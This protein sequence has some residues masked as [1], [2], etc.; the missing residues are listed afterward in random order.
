MRERQPI[1]DT[2]LAHYRL[3]SAQEH[4]RAREAADPMIRRIHSTLAERYDALIDNMVK[5]SLK[6]VRESPSYGAA[7][8]GQSN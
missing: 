3:R 5:H 7:S 4:E 8:L 1:D 2:T 6:I